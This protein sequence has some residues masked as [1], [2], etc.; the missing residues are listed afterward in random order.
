MQRKKWIGGFFNIYL[1]GL[2]HA[3]Y[4]CT[5]NN[6][7]GRFLSQRRGAGICVCTLRGLTCIKCKTIIIIFYML[8]TELLDLPS[9]G[10]LFKL[11][12]KV[13]NSCLLVITSSSIYNYSILWVR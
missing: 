13:I 12:R 2:R 11:A 7:I 9:D 10:N 4:G 1:I 3:C 8:D 6:C 5:R